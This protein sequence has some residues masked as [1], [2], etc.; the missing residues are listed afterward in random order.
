[1]SEIA[2]ADMSAISTNEEEE[3]E[4]QSSPEFNGPLASIDTIDDLQFYARPHTMLLKQ[5]SKGYK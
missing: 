4:P 2:S 3:E 1:M 5:Y